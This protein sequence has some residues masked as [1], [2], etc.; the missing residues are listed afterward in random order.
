MQ[1][2][3]CKI[4]EEKK[5]NKLDKNWIKSKSKKDIRINEDDGENEAQQGYK[6]KNLGV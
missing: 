5:C 3:K 6:K 2:K 1:T 4:E